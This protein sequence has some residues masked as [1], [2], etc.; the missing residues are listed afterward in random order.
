M[1]YLFMC[2]FVIHIETS[3]TASCLF[4]CVELTTVHEDAESAS[5]L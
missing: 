1:S 4:T 5:K 2:L 3:T